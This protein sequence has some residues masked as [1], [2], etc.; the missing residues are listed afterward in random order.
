MRLTT[1]QIIGLLQLQGC[2]RVTTIKV[3]N[4]AHSKQKEIV[5]LDDFCDLLAMCRANKIVSRL[6][7]YSVDEIDTAFSLADRIIKKSE[8][9]NIGIVSYFDED[10]PKRLKNMTNV[11]GAFISPLVLYTRDKLYYQELEEDQKLIENINQKIYF[12]NNSFTE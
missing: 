12:G 8:E 2:G 9:A 7:E 6:K 3:A 11:K 4:Y 10:F 1:K 5:T